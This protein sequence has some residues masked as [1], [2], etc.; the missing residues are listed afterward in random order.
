VISADEVARSPLWFPLERVERDGIRMVRL[1]EAAYHAAS[2]LDQRVLSGAPEQAVCAIDVLE[3]AAASLVPRLHYIFHTGHVGSTLLSRLIG[4]HEAFFSLREPALL[5]EVAPRAAPSVSATTGGLS[6]GSLLALLARTWHAE[7][8]AVLKATSFLSEYASIILA[9]SQRPAAILMFVQPLVYLRT[10]LGG[11]NS[12]IEARTLATS[13]L[14]RLAQRLG[15]AEWHS[16][17]RSEGEYIAMSWLC[18]MAA[19]HQVA[20]VG[21]GI[22]SAAGAPDRR[23]HSQVL[24]VEF[25]R[26]LTDPRGC[27]HGILRTL[28]TDAS[29]R[30]IEAL[31]S[32]PLMRQYSK[33]PE[34]AYDAHTRREV[35]SAVDQPY[36]T[37]LKRGMDWLD[38]MA[39]HYALVASILEGVRS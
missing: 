12:R 26:F 38:R 35:L 14:R 23:E 13:R 7:Q 16:G 39:G 17:V 19:L 20:P 30:E 18:E 3:S 31:V 4:E 32:R 33:A 8:R 1:H 5:R 21:S 2:F 25:D 11:P 15:D 27:L 28:G 9:K 34:Y 36:G 6:L 10:I 22:T 24:W 29:A 37:E